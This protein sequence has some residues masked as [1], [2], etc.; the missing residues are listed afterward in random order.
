MMCTWGGKHQRNAL[1]PTCYFLCKT[2]CN[3]LCRRI[4]SHLY[5]FSK[6]KNMQFEN[7][8]DFLIIYLKRGKRVENEKKGCCSQSCSNRFDCKPHVS[9]K[10]KRNF[11]VFLSNGMRIR[12]VYWWRQKRWCWK[13]R[14]VNIVFKIVFCNN[15][16]PVCIRWSLFLKCIFYFC[17]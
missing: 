11:A 9:E 13:I 15:F 1:T 3:W 10:V 4:C 16:L 12:L 2:L 17:L 5:F 8:I 6:E 14:W 7:V